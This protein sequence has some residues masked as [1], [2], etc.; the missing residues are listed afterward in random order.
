MPTLAQEPF[1]YPED[2]LCR[3]KLEEES[4]SGLPTQWWVLRTHPQAEKAV[5][6][7]LRRHG[8]SYFL[9]IQERE[10]RSRGRVVTA[11]LPL[12]PGYIFLRGTHDDRHLAYRTNQIITTVEI[13]NQ[14]QLARELK[15]VHRLM[16]GNQPIYPID[17]LEPG[18]QVRVIRGCLVG[19]VGTVLAT[20]LKNEN[21]LRV[22][23]AMHTLNRGVATDLPAKWVIPLD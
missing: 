21:D 16:T 17:Q 5:G 9:P 2:L 15:D 1:V 13:K 19:T 22:V 20:K 23:I 18:K 7:W 8:V 12:F 14:E 11:Y 10:R 6:R 3:Q 4:D